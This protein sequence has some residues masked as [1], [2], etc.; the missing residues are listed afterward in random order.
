[1]PRTMTAGLSLS[2]CFL[3]HKSFC[4]SQTFS[5]LDYLHQLLYS[6]SDFI[7]YL[8]FVVLLLHSPPLSE[9]SYCITWC[10]AVCVSTEPRLCAILVLAVNVMHCIQCSLV[11]FDTAGCIISLILQRAKL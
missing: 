6:L 4:A 8:L 7:A 3:L 1:M 9:G 11:W 5:A 2:F 10:H